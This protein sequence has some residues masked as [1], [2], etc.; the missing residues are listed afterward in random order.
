MYT[1]FAHP[2]V[3][4]LAAFFVFPHSSSIADFTQPGYVV[5]ALLYLTGLV[6]VTASTYAAAEVEKV[7]AGEAS[8]EA[9]GTLPSGAIGPTVAVAVRTLAYYGLM[10]I[11]ARLAYWL[12]FAGV[13]L[14]GGL[15]ASVTMYW[16]H[17]L[18]ETG[19]SRVDADLAGYRMATRSGLNWGLP[20][21][22]VAMLV[23]FH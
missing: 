8:K 19:L 20:A 16:R 17:K 12:P 3:A 4:G 23:A 11:G 21:A 1:R 10:V 13:L 22:L 18:A 6:G 14:S 7:R 5:V 15:V 2:L 9:N